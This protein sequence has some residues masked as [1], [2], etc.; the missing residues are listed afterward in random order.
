[1]KEDAIIEIIE[2]LENLD[3]F[4]FSG[5]AIYIY[6]KGKRKFQDILL[7]FDDLKE[8]AKRLSVKVEKRLIKK[9]NFSTETY[10]FKTNYKGQEIDAVTYNLNTSDKINCLLQLKK[11][12]KA[13][14]SGKNIFLEP[15]EGILI[16]KI[17]M[18]RENEDLKLLSKHIKKINLKFLKELSDY[19]EIPYENIISKL[20]DF[21]FL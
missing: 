18:S 16:H 3:Y 5:F 20:K 11:K 1:M 13:E 21:D 14:I 19:S 6:T 10:N 9:G 7:T 17:T 15:I 8:L 12:T 4:F 2:K